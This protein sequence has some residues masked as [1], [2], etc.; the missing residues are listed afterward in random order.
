MRMSSYAYRLAPLVAAT[1]VLAF[2]GTRPNTQPLKPTYPSSHLRLLQPQ[3][4]SAS[5]SVETVPS[6]STHQVDEGARR[7]DNEAPGPKLDPPPPAIPPPC[8]FD[9]PV[10]LSVV[11]SWVSYLSLL[12]VM[13]VSS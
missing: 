13:S 5:N 4:S 12:L 6:K 7:R 10:D 8:Q 1:P 3:S 11:V 2:L 9:D